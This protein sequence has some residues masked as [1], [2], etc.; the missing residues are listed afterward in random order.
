VKYNMDTNIWLG[1]LRLTV[2]DLD[3][4]RRFYASAMGM[5]VLD[6]ADDRLVVG[7]DQ[8]LL[9]LDGAPGVSPDSGQYTGLYH[10]ALLVPSRASLGAWAAGW[11][12]SGLGMPGQGDH[13]VSEALY[14]SDP[15]GHGIEIYC[16]RPRESWAW[17]DGAV[18]MTTGPVD[19]VSMIDEARAQG[20]VKGKLSGDTR[21]GH[22]H[23]RVS[24]LA[25]SK[26]FYVEI[27]GFDI[28]AQL[29]GALFVSVGGYHHNVGMNTWHSRGASASPKSMARLE[30]FDIRLDRDGLQDV[31]SRLS[32]A[33]HAI[34]PLD[35]GFLAVDPSGNT[36]RFVAVGSPS[37]FTT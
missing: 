15:D 19:I 34:T 21:L 10:Y 29:P 7:S 18:Q 8:P 20:L 11:I 23:L 22:I 28:T 33:Q 9:I 24:D 12:D 31:E 13:G 4:S 30:S 27:L 14:V 3:R 16:D 1:P 25:A 32:R 5:Q 37:S 2:A 17:K 35:G 36:I 6:E 26:Y